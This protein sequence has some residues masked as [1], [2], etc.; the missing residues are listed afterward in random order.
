MMSG[1]GQFYSNSISL[2]SG[3]S[4]G[5]SGGGADQ[6]ALYSRNNFVGCSSGGVDYTK[7]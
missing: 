5:Y 7:Q 6:G 3:M 4:I 2:G 1:P